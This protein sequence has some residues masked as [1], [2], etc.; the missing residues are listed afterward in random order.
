MGDY[1]AA[2]AWYGVVNSAATGVRW[3]IM[4]AVL[5][6]LCMFTLWIL[7][8]MFGFQGILPMKQ[9]FTNPPPYVKAFTQ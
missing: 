4:I 8:K 3:Y 9:G 6:T 5:V 7:Y 2:A 1:S